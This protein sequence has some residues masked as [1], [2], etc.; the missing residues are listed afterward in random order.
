M[1]V[2]LVPIGGLV[3]GLALTLSV[4]VTPAWAQTTNNGPASVGRP[5][6]CSEDY[7]LDLAQQGA[8]GMT[9]LSFTI[10][11]N[12]DVHDLKVSRS[13][14]ISG[15][16]EAALSCA[17]R[18][19]YKPAMRDGKPVAI[20]WS[21]A[22]QF[23]VT[24]PLVP[25]VLVEKENASSGSNPLPPDGRGHCSGPPDLIGH[26]IHGATT[27][28]F[29][30]TETGNVRNISVV[31]SSGNKELDDAAI[32]CAQSRLYKPASRGGSPMAVFVESKTIWHS[33]PPAQSGPAG[34]PPPPSPNP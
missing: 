31:E 15:L 33:G 24:D 13:S 3:R 20:P 8:E 14:G 21:A 27:V 12:G 5:H 25:P 30:V 19:H 16:D 29:E 18:W 26:D 10:D 4:I 9:V 2:G 7:P 22:V 1:R 17:A 28:R 6:S 34:S 11:E 32:S 23:R